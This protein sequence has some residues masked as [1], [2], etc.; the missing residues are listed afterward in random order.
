M[1]NHYIINLLSARIRRNPPSICR[2]QLAPSVT[3][4]TTNRRT[5]CILNVM[6]HW[7]YLFNRIIWPHISPLPLSQQSRHVQRHRQAASLNIFAPIHIPF[8]PLRFQATLIRSSGS[9]AANKN[10]NKQTKKKQQ[11]Q[12]TNSHSFSSSLIALGQVWLPKTSKVGRV[13][14]RC[15]GV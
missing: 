7:K 11:L 4:K 3:L 9:F 5:G 10:Q 12:S 1:T 8:L 6:K 15:S 2:E 14:R 13:C